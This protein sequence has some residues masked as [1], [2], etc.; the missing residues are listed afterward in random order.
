MHVA[1]I[2]V[3]ESVAKVFAPEALIDDLADVAPDVTL[4]TEADDLSTVDALVTLAYDDAFLD[5]D[6]DW[7][8]SIQA[9]VDRFPFDELEAHGITL[10]NSTGIHG[11]SVGETTVGYILMLARRL[12]VYAANQQEH[13]WEHPVW[14][15]PFTATGRTL[16]VVGLGTL[17]QG[18]ATRAAALGMH[19][20]GVKRTVESVP[21]VE[22]VFPTTDLH[23][24]ISGADFVALACPLTEET[25]HLF[26][27]AAFAAM[28]N[29]SYLLNVARGPVVDTEAFVEA[30][31]TGDIA[32]GALDVFEE[33]PLPESSPLWDLD[34]VIL[35]PHRAGSD[36]AYYEGVAGLV[37]ENLARLEREEQFTNLVV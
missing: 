3:H 16:C 24:A 32:G 17:G 31:Q 37:R 36:R 23:E 10:T 34:D 9:G 22:R 4:V 20:V 13:V 27:A 30:V 15:E 2:G 5:A 7:I 25:H 18:I 6:L 21:D 14:D 8:H 19:V 29:E 26:D 35:T 12:H 28:D 33:E 1:R 11:A